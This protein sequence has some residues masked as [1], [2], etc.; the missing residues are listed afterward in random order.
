MTFAP[1]G[2]DSAVPTPA[3]ETPASAPAEPADPTTNL[4][5]PE[6][7][8][9]TETAEEFET[10]EFDG[11]EYQVPKA[12]KPAIM[13]N[14]DY[15]EKTQKLSA[16]NRE[17]AE[18][19]AL[20]G[21][22]ADATLE[23]QRV[24]GRLSMVDDQ[25]ASLVGREMALEDIGR[26]NWKEWVIRDR[27]AA[28]RAAKFLPTLLRDRQRHES[29]LRQHGTQR[30][31]RQE[32]ETASR[33]KATIEF[34]KDN[35]TGWNN[36]LANQLEDYAEREF[37]IAGPEFEAWLNPKNLRALHK[38]WLADQLQK[39]PQAKAETPSSVTPLVRVQTRSSP[40]AKKSL[41]EMSMDEYVAERK[42]QNTR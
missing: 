6:E 37:E 1:E 17:L 7:S 39:Q 26:I 10:V 3:P 29:E 13:K 34:A 24:V 31:Q 38:A 30:T 15:T 32:Q 42:K 23:E 21:K 36:E 9:E 8:P 25:I 4:N 20:L 22:Y 35:I 16:R 41:A 5:L 14:A 11:R 18:R 33:L 19:E 28:E 40:G 12:L 27:A 2:T